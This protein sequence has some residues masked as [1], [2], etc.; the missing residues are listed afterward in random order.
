MIA[1]L[2]MCVLFL[3]T[4]LNN[5]LSKDVLR[6]SLGVCIAF[7]FSCVCALVNSGVWQ[8][9][10]SVTC[11]L[12]ILLACSLYSINDTGIFFLSEK[13]IRRINKKKNN[14]SS[15]VPKNWFILFSCLFMLLSSILYYRDLR[16]ITSR[17]GTYASWY[18]MI[19]FYR[20]GSMMGIIEEGVSFFASNAY[21][22]STALAYLH[23]YILVHNI[24]AGKK[25]NRSYVCLVP[26][27]I[28]TIN[29]VFTGGRLP[30]LRLLIGGVFLFFFF[31][32]KKNGSRN[33]NIKRFFK[34]IVL[35]VAVLYA[36]ANVSTLFG[37]FY[38]GNPVYY[39]T[40]YIGGS[41][42]LFDMFLE[43]PIKH[44]VWGYETFPSILNFLRRRI[45]GFDFPYIPVN[46]EFRSMNNLQI[47]NVYTALRAYISDFGYLGM[48][49]LVLFHSFFYSN[50][51][52]YILKKQISANAIDFSILFY[53]YIVHA[54][55]LFSIDDRFYMDICSINTIKIVFIFWIFTHLKRIK[56][57]VF[58]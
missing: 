33:I 46:K 6:P 36:F 21:I 57:S 3:L 19:R 48:G 32:F 14:F 45:S 28:F 18:S 35:V 40:S 25:D 55:Y 52:N 58:K 11:F 49:I 38:D 41:I 53:S 30:I 50:Y 13:K 39:V 1:I 16:Y 43:D 42:P 2:L 8:Y 12:V 24:T 26:I 34:L 15:L 54:V 20:N 7:I 10:M 56:I 44:S 22:V 29:T 51:Y 31:T 4:M 5:A 37:R 27:A 23:M 17:Y 9:R 47:G